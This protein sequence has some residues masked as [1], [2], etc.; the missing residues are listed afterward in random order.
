MRC[1]RLYARYGTPV[2]SRRVLPKV[3]QEV[4]ANMIGTTRPHVNFFMNKFKKLGFIEYDKSGLRV[5]HT[6]LNVVQYDTP[7]FGN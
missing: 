7:A 3:S 6:L 2:G 4:L 1:F 5:H